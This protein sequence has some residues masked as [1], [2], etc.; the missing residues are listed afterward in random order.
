MSKNLLHKTK[1]GEFEKWLTERGVQH[2]KT[3]GEW[4]VLQVRVGRDWLSVYERAHMS[5]H[6]SVDRRMDRLVEEFCRANRN[7]E[8][9]TKQ[10]ST[11]P[12]EDM[13]WIY[14]PRH[15]EYLS[16]YADRLRKRR[17]AAMAS[18]PIW[19]IEEARLN[20]IMRAQERD[21]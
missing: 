3:T 6:F 8:R 1:L 5:E 21:E 15:P 2:R 10:L 4:Q 17:A 14:D 18:A 7:Q 11:E 9:G 12:D 16:E 19:M 13:R 20:E